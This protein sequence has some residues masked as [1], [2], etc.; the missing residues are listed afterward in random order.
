MRVSQFA[1]GHG[2]VRSIALAAVMAALPFAAAMPTTARADVIVI[3]IGQVQAL[4]KIDALSKADFLARVTIAGETFVTPVIRNQDNIYPNWSVRKTVAP[5]IYDIK[6]EILD[7]DVTKNDYVDINARD[8]KRDLDFQVDTR[9]C[10]VLGFAQPYRC[11]SPIARR[12]NERKK[13]EVTFA[14]D[15]TR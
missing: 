1:Y 4:D 10:R 13:A 7:K 12:G 6:L 2:R 8:N 9:R 15:V 5:G 14:V 11:G 3:S